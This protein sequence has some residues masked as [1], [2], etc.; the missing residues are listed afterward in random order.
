MADV[1]CSN[2]L[3]A[4]ADAL[5]R[6][7]ERPLASPFMKE[8]ILVPSPALGAWLSSELA[9]R[10]G[11]WANPDFKTP[12]AWLAEL[13]SKDGSDP[14]AP[15]S[16]T[17]TIAAR[18]PGYLKEKEFASVRRY[19]EDD[20]DGTKRL[21]LARKLAVLFDRY[22][23][24]RPDLV[25]AWHHGKSDGEWQAQLFRG[26]VAEHHFADLVS[27]MQ[28]F[29]SKL[30]FRD[31]L[32]ERLSLF[33][34]GPLPA[35]VQEAIEAVGAL[36]PVHTFELEVGKPVAPPTSLLGRVQ[37]AP[38]GPFDLAD[39]SVTVH[40]CHSATRE[41]EVLRDQLL[42]ALATMPDL[43]PRDI[44]VLCPDLDSYAVAIESVFGVDPK[45]PRHLPYRIADRSSGASLPVAEGLL[46]LLDVA[47]SRMTAP[48]V[49][50][51]LYR[52]PIR[53]RFGLSEPDVETIRTWIADSGIRWGADET[54][55]AEVGQ[56][57]LRQNT[58]AF[59]LDRL[60]LGYAMGGEDTFAGVL[61]T[62]ELDGGSGK[63]LGG[64][65]DFV[66]K[67]TALRSSSSEFPEKVSQE[68][69]PRETASASLEPATFTVWRDRLFRV[70]ERFLASTRTTEFQHQVV[71]DALDALVATGFAEEVPLAVV[72]GALAAELEGSGGFDAGTGGI[73]FARLAPGR[74]VPARVVA[75]LGMNDG[76][77]PRASRPLGFDLL[78]DDGPSPRE[79]DRRVFQEALL[80]ARE[81]LV[82][83]YV[84]RSI[85]NDAERPPS[86]VVSEML[87][88]LPASSR[89]VITHPLHAFSPKYFVPERGDLFS[90]ASCET[91][92]AM[93]GERVPEPSFVAGPVPAPPGEDETRPVTIDE[94]CTFFAHPVE[95]FVKRRV[96]AFMPRD[97]PPLEDREPFEL[98]GLQKWAIQNPLVARAREE[99]VS[100]MPE[101]IRASGKLP[102]GTPGEV[103]Y[104]TLF[105]GPAKMA[106]IVNAALGNGTPTP[107]EIDVPLPGVAGARV[108]GWLRTVGPKAQ[109][110]HRYSNARGKHELDAWIRHLAMLAQG[111][112]KETLLV[113][114]K[115]DGPIVQRFAI[116]DRPEQHLADLV[117]LFREGQR[118][119]LPLFPDPAL[120]YVQAIAKGKSPD[121]ALGIAR[122]TYRGN[123]HGGGFDGGNNAYVTKVYGESDPIHP[124]FRLFAE[125]HPRFV[126][127]A[128]RVFRPILAHLETVPV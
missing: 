102:L 88:E 89:I 105:P 83:T 19:L 68:T 108:I 85:K 15:A 41:C 57:S 79:E 97:V 35:L 14:F 43:E 94:L 6:V 39:R 92:K 77:F 115:G 42:D 21:A 122:N 60:L 1:Y 16:L 22:I 107:L 93:L 52:E 36:I 101:A 3:E 80:A 75:L 111:V 70:L 25:R 67:L 38:R 82:V 74:T 34:V 78:G 33:C 50:D 71:R 84:G 109:V 76:V 56:P 104:E 103:L 8:A 29:A 7:V 66:G 31:D 62:D 112:R 46:A 91:A 30:E 117:A 95:A 124:D 64:F 32:P 12:R 65:A 127:V 47:T 98:D 106:A 10:Q 86:V 90:Y 126:D 48:A 2:R 45:D 72:Q 51:L 128:D 59:G 17:W 9:K 81:R 99:D 61:P 28:G 23:L 20:T 110:I 100:T 37:G 121:V 18:L 113:A 55:R 11:I 58:W 119:P 49:L 63:A 114:K 24:H 118:M 5:A 13:T 40:A 116:V 4:L 69:H 73:T 27:Q 123:A 44:R 26:A 125:E 54:H 87:D 120:E 53:A 96:G